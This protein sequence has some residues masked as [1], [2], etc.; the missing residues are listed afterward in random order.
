MEEEKLK[1]VIC[2]KFI[3]EDWRWASGCLCVSCQKT[4][5]KQYFEHIE[6]LASIRDE[7]KRPVTLSNENKASIIQMLDIALLR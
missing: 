5:M 7:L 6:N 1:C 2:K 3:K 4:S